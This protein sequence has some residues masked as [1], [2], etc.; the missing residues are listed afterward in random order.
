MK[1]RISNIIS[2]LFIG[3]LVSLVGGFLQA[4]KLK[5]GVDIP[6]GLI[7][8]YVILI[9]AVGLVRKNTRKRYNVALFGI[10][11]LIVALLM[12]TRTTAGDLVLTDNL[13]AKI[14]LLSSV[15]YIGAMSTLPLRKIK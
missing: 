2:A 15:I 12:S 3:F 10:S 9:W 8:Y 6:W 11:W 13:I 7:F 5:L 1:D 14:Y 4:A